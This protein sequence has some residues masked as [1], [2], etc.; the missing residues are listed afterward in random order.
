M[1][2]KSTYKDALKTLRPKQRSHHDRTFED[3]ATA[4]LDTQSYKFIDLTCTLSKYET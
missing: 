4:I 3:D 1:Q 2:T